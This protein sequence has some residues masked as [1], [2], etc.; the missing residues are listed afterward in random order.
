MAYISNAQ[1]VKTSKLVDGINL[2]P[3]KEYDSIEVFIDLDNS[4][5]SK[6]NSWIKPTPGIEHLILQEIVELGSAL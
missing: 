5:N 4:K 6:D 3:T 1:V 2:G